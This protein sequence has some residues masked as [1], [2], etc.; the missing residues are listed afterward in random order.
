MCSNRLQS[1]YVPPTAV[2]ISAV[3]PGSLPY[4]SELDLLVFKV[5]SCGLRPTPAK[6]LRDATDARTLAEDL[7]SKG[8]ISLSLTQKD[9]VLNGLD[10]V[11]QLS[12]KD[13]T[14]WASRLGLS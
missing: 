14:W 12:R 9:A 1:P 13:K 11:V 10:D 2:P 4:I 3:R 8:P 5:N 7:G 6:K